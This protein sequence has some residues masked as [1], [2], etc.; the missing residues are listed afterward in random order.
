YVR[1]KTS[2]PRFVA[3]SAALLL[4][5]LG[6]SLELFLDLT[7]VLA[8][9]GALALAFA[10]SPLRRAL[11]RV[12]RLLLL[13][14]AVCLPVAAAVAAAALSTPHGPTHHVPSDSSVDLFN[15]VAPTPTRLT[16]RLHA[17]RAPPPPL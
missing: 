3:G 4:I 10:R 14:Y 12:A 2:P 1:G 11:M 13:A 5:L 7:L 6:S 16:R 9:V 17:A 15:L 8:C